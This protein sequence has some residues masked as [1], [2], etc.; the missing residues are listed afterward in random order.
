MQFLNS[1]LS[2]NELK[3]LYILLPPA[4]LCTPTP[5]QLLNGA[6]NPDTRHKAPRPGDVSRLAFDILRSVQCKSNR[7]VGLQFLLA[8]VMSN[9]TS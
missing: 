2:S 5:S 1:A 8:S 4:H 9:I 3:A 6:Y 7:R